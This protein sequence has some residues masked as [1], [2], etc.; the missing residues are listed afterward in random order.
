MTGTWLISYLALWLVV[1]LLLFALFVLARQIG[2][3]HR[4]IGPLGARMTNAGPAVGERVPALHAV[5]L[6]GRPVE[7]GYTRGKQTLVVFVSATCTSCTELAPAIRSIWK[8]ERATHDVVLVSLG[9]DETT[10]RAFVARH[11]LSDIPYVV[12][13]DLGLAYQVLTTPY[14]LLIDQQGILRAKGIVNHLEHLESLLNAAQLGHP[15]VESFYRAQ[16][17]DHSGDTQPA[18]EVVTSQQSNP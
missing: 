10:N 9:G 2:L 14:G 11:K 7:L 4:R 18:L 6:Q 5:D 16:H 8:S 15:S 12:S 1:M 13:S 17:G 3:L